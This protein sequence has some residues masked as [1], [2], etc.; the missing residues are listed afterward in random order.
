MENVQ[1]KT[2]EKWTYAD[3]MNWPDDVRWELMDGV[4][5]AMSPAPNRLH[6]KLSAALFNQIYSH[7]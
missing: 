1:M 2:D 3:Y 5:Y 4:A 6:Q 7:L